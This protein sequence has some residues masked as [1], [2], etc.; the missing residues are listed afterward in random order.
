MTKWA[1][2]PNVTRVTVVGHDGISFERYNLYLN[3]AELH[4]QDDGKTLKLFPMLED[5]NF[6]APLRVGEWGWDPETHTAIH[7]PSYNLAKE[8]ETNGTD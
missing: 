4:L 1:D 5:E 6:Q 7:I 3:G 2:F 8:R